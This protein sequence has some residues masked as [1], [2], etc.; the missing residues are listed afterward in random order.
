MHDQIGAGMTLPGQP[1][2][3]DF[4]TRT[5]VR[6]EG[7]SMVAT[8]F[9]IG[10]GDVEIIKAEIDLVPIMKALRRLH[11]KLHAEM[12]VSGDDL[13]DGVGALP[14]VAFAW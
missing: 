3:A 11:N 6:Q 2:V 4:W 5:H 7:T 1:G 13:R 14:T 9:I 12:N 10:N 8:T